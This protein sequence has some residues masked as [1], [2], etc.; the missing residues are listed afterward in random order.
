L[1][2]PVRSRSM[3]FHPTSP[4]IALGM[5]DRRLIVLDVTT[6]KTQL[7]VTLDSAPIEL[8]FRPDG[9]A[10][11]LAMGASGRV[12]VRDCNR[13]RVL[14]SFD[15][16]TEVSAVGWSSDARYIIAGYDDARACVWE[17]ATGRKVATLKG[18]QA[19][20]VDTRFLPDSRIAITY[21]W[22]ETTRLWDAFTGEEL[23]A[24]S[25]RVLNLSRDGKRL[26]FVTG[27]K[28]GVW[29]VLYGEVLRTLHGHTGKNP[30]A[31]GISSDSR[32]AASGGD[33]GILL[34]DLGNYRLLGSLPAGKVVDV[35]FDPTD[36]VFSCGSSGLIRW[37]LSN[38]QSGVLSHRAEKLSPEPCRDATMDTSGRVVAHLTAGTV[39]VLFLKEPSRNRQL[40]AS[41]GSSQLALS[42][43]G[44][45][46]AAGHWR[47]NQVSVWN[48]QSGELGTSLLRGSSTASAIFSPD[49]KWLVTGT[50]QDYRLW[51]VPSWREASKIERP[52]RFSNLPGRMA[53]SADGT[54]LAAVM[55]QRSVRLFRIGSGDV[56][57]TF[58]SDE[59]QS[60]TALCF[61]PNRELFA[62]ATHANQI[63]IWDL[64]RIRNELRR[65]KLDTPREQPRH[66]ETR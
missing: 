10:I 53:I 59:P 34:W 25:D 20:V 41:R 55:D 22:D 51:S 61:S 35:F 2:Q 52:P 9:R 14:Q 13:G 5:M 43:G 19:E 16:P 3:D 6:A 48:T 23:L 37:T 1:E 38:H 66:A 21:S 58:E 33:D 47:G 63:Q 8:R 46:V 17:V 64:G 39:S 24:A 65:V 12:D 54:I 28:L 60:I 11:A 26:S 32:R 7:E 45:W 57:A 56:V 29:E 50:S 36:A 49:S 62:A 15:Y 31:M 44:E 27:Q 30:R 40:E 18:H 42:P 4:L